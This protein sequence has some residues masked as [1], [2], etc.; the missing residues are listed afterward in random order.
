M[1][2]YL[3]WQPHISIFWLE[4][5][6]DLWGYFATFVGSPIGESARIPNGEIIQHSSPWGQFRSGWIE[7]IP[8]KESGASDRSRDGVIEY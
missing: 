1:Q 2:L 8:S 7:P 5:P 4:R 6:G 3:D